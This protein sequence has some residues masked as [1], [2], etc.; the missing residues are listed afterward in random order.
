MAMEVT[1][2]Q[3]EDLRWVYQIDGKDSEGSWPTAGEA[4]R[5]A[6]AAL[7]AM[8]PKNDAWKLILLVALA[9]T[10]VLWVLAYVGR[11]LGLF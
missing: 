4:E 10:P 2:R 5:G 11:L 9:S 1:T 7:K 6:Y 3:R 8:R